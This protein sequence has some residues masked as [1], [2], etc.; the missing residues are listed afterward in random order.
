[1]LKKQVQKICLKRMTRINVMM[2]FNV[3]GATGRS[4]VNVDLE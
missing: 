2:I 3:E 1:M 4:V